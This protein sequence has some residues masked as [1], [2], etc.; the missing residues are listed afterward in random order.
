MKLL[1]FCFGGW[2]YR[3]FSL[4]V[5]TVLRIRGAKVGK[6]LRV[7]GV[8]RLKLR[9]SA[10]HIVIG[11]DVQITGDLDLRNREGGRI[12]IGDR[13]KLDHGVRLVAARN[14]VL[15]IGEDSNIGAYSILNCGADVTIGRGCLVSGF[16]YIQ[17]S[18]HGTRKGIPIKDQ[19]HTH[20]EIVIGDDVWLGAH[21]SVLSGT[22]IASGAVIGS[23]AV[24]T[25]SVAPDQI[26]AGVPAHP[27]GSRSE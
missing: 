21:A 23:N 11:D 16:V 26:V 5:A 7:E 13:V 17:S 10:R 15:R 19:P 18:D 3:P 27:I 25:K 14:A 12:E 4:L 9:G 22:R 6:R 8:P 1:A 20:E 24:V 2:V